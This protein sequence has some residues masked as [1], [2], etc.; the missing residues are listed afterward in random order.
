MHRA[1]GAVRSHEFGEPGLGAPVQVKISL[2]SAIPAPQRPPPSI[3]P[4]CSSRSRSSRSPALISPP[5]PPRSPPAFRPSR[6]ASRESDPDAIRALRLFSEEPLSDE[7]E[8][9]ERLFELRQQVSQL[10]IELDAV[11][12]GAE[13]QGTTQFDEKLLTDAQAELLNPTPEAPESPRAAGLAPET[14]ALIDQIHAPGNEH[15]SHAP[16]KLPHTGT[17]PVEEEGY[18]ADRVLHARACLRAGRFEKGLA[19]LERVPEDAA[20]FF[21]RGRLLE[22]L[23]RIEEAIAAFDEALRLDGEGPNARA[24]SERLSFLTWKRDFLRSLPEDAKPKTG[25]VR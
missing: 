1:L 12:G 23:D 7:R 3:D 6:S 14:L 2:R 18:S 10:Q 20:V 13:V 24:A 15:V 4:K 22:E 25:G 5:T 21:W 19:L 17:G 8:R 16:T 9:D 11:E